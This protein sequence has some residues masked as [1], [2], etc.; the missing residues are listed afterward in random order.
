LEC[1]EESVHIDVLVVLLT[2]R[3]EGQDCRLRI[4]MCLR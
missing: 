1:L 2:S 4:E 3:P